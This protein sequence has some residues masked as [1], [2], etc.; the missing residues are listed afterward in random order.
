MSD[1]T[2]QSPK[3]QRVAVTH[4]SPNA[5]IVLRDAT[6]TPGRDGTLVPEQYT[7]RWGRACY[8]CG[9]NDHWYQNCPFNTRP[10]QS[11]Y[12]GICY[13]C[14]GQIQPGTPGVSFGDL[15][16]PVHDV[17]Q[18]SYVR[19]QQRAPVSTHGVPGQSRAGTAAATT[20]ST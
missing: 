9:N 10:F 18:L 5:N 19:E 1:L 15:G 13:L 17:C 8:R 11:L 12:G 20:D 6:S 14:N 16:Q 3:R 7:D 2:L 4:S